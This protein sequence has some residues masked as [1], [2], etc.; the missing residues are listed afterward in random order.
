MSIK[1]KVA[2]IT[3]ASGGLGGTVAAHFA[4]QGARL[5]AVYRSP[6][7]LP[8]LQEALSEGEHLL[9]QADVTDEEQVEK[10][11]AEVH[12]R[13]GGPDILLN[14]VGGWAGGQRLPDLDLAIWQGMLTMNLTSAFL[15]SKHAL[16]YMLPAGYGRIVNVA[17]KGAFDMVPGVAAYAVAKSGVMALTTCLAHE[18]KGTG[19]AASCVVPSVID[20]PATRQMMPGDPSHWITPQHLAETMAW[21]AS[22]EGGAANGAIV[23]LYGAL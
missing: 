9:L 12:E 22:V 10:L 5:A 20:T 8:E 2:L 13:L 14:L 15:C 3:G 11:L 7:K 18:L 19:V 1:G 17:S 6:D 23:P 21:L 16:K 4:Q